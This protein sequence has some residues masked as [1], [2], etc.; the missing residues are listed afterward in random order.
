MCMK[1]RQITK[2]VYFYFTLVPQ[3][4]VKY[5]PPTNVIIFNEPTGFKFNHDVAYELLWEM[6]LVQT[7]LWRDSLTCQAYHFMNTGIIIKVT[8]YMG[9]GDLH[10]YMQ[11]VL[12]L[13]ECVNYTTAYKLYTIFKD[14]CFLSVVT[15][16]LI[17]NCCQRIH[18]LLRYL[19]FELNNIKV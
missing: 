18:P 19:D 5:F 2:W 15:T 4:S 1:N 10:N 6:H 14:N 8:Y 13:N 11:F 9:K 16:L 7:S 12:T 17:S 3:Y